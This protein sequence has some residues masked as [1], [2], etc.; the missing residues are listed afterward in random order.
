MKWKERCL[1][2]YPQCPVNDDEL[3]VV[4]KLYA[5]KSWKWISMSR[6]LKVNEQVFKY[7]LLACSMKY[8]WVNSVRQVCHDFVF[9]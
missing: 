2:C 5:D 7:D 6:D 9:N 8:H 3:K 4:Y 1:T